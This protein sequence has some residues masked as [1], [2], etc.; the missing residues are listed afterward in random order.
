MKTVVRIVT[1]L[2]LLF[3][4]L[5]W[6]APVDAKWNNNNGR[7]SLDWRGRVDDTIDLH[8]QGRSVRSVVISGRRPQNVRY[9]FDGR[10]PRRTTL[11]R[12]VVKRGRGLIYIRQLPKSSN[13]YTAIVRITDSR[14]GI[15]NYRI[16][17]Q[18]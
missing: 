12:I 6:S 13:N 3:V 14:R 5:V 9:D 7:N 10:L 8:I 2:F 11:V 17:M 15:D 18:W 1:S 16:R 4:C